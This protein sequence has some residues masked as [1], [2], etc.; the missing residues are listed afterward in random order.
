KGA[1]KRNGWREFVQQAEPLLIHIGGEYH[2]TC[3]VAAGAVKALHQAVSD[4]I[5]RHKH[6]RDRRGCVLRCERAEALPPVA[7]STFTRRCTSSAANAGSRPYLP[8]AHRYSIVTFWPSKKPDSPRPLRNACKT[9]P[10]SSGER[11]LMNPI[12]GNADCCARTENGH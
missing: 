3:H 4:W 5:T 1:N 10:L 2:R 9:G 12:T 6:D 7:T 11:A 8:R